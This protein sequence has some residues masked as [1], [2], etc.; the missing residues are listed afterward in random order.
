MSKEK[1]VSAMDVLHLQMMRN[2]IK[3]FLTKMAKDYEFAGARVLDVAPQVH[4]GAKAYFLQSRIETLDID[5]ESGADIIADI[6]KTNE[7]IADETYDF[8]VCTEVLEHTLNPF[9]A[10]AELARILKSDGKLFL[11][12]PFNFRIHGPLPDCWR[13]TEHGLRAMLS[14]YFVI[15]DLQ[16]LETPDRWLMPVHYTVRLSKN[17]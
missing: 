2:N 1:T 11:T 7:G 8:V 12:V 13:F 14:P 3:D 10:V 9:A 6:C 15:E 17:A 16:A 4:E 5:P